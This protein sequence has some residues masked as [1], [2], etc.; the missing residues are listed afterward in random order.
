MVGS[1]SAQA[2]S[3][4][5]KV[6]RKAPIAAQATTKMA[7]SGHRIRAGKGRTCSRL[8]SSCRPRSHCHQPQTAIV[9]KKICRLASPYNLLFQNSAKYSSELMMASGQAIGLTRM[10]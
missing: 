3:V 2:T 1:A 9:A 10:L 4:S 8:P 6:F 7:S 5:V